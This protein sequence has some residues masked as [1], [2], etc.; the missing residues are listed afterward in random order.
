MVVGMWLMI[1]R[2]LAKHKMDCSNI[3][4][5]NGFALNIQHALVNR[6]SQDRG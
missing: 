4:G 2:L 3:L 6:T 5:L 1:A